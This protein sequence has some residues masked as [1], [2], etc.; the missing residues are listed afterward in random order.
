MKMM[1]MM[2]NNYSDDM[3]AMVTISMIGLMMMMMTMMMMMMM[4]MMKLRAQYTTSACCA[5]PML[6]PWLGLWMMLLVGPSGPVM[7]PSLDGSFKILPPR[8]LAMNRSASP[9]ALTVLREW[10][11]LLCKGK[12]SAYG[13]SAGDGGRRTRK[14]CFSGVFTSTLGGSSCALSSNGLCKPSFSETDDD[15]SRMP[16]MMTRPSRNRVQ[17]GRMSRQWTSP[18]LRGT[19]YADGRGAMKFP[20]SPRSPT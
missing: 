14:T 10:Q 16:T 2:M 7:R 12:E 15:E 19:R 18:R 8:P 6:P 3:V 17:K 20:W 9:M 1:I 11:E 4:M 13:F 5:T